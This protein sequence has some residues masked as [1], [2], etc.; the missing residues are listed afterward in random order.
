MK[1]TRKSERADRDNPVWTKDTFGRARKARDVLPEILGAATSARLLKPRGRP[2]TGN[3]RT[4]ISLRLPPETLARWKATGPG[5]QTRMA[6][7]LTK[8]V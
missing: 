4:L 1:R 7:A 6:D 2:K 8:A 5:W 3:A